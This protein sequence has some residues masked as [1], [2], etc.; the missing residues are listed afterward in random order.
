MIDF[1]G[2]CS[3]IRSLLRDLLEVVAYAI[4]EADGHHDYRADML[5]WKLRAL[6]A[7]A[8][9]QAR[10]AVRLEHYSQQSYGRWGAN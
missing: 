1:V 4:R 5:V 9:L 8:E 3:M 2:A 10:D 6:R 7:E